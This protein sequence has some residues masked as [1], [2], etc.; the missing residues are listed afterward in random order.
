[1]L[2]G[3]YELRVGM[4][5]K[6]NLYVEDEHTDGNDPYDTKLYRS[7]RKASKNEK[8]NIISDLQRKGVCNFT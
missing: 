1:M 5:G 2:T 7:W 3:N 6:I 8:Y 4:F